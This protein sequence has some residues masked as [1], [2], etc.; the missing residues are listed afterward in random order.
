MNYEKL[1]ES[2]LTKGL[3]KKQMPNLRT[4]EK[5]ILRARKD[6]K[7]A[8]ATLT[9]DEGIAYAVA[10]LAMLRAGRAV[11]LL[12]GFR[13]AD[14][15]Q[16][17]TVV[18]FIS[19]L[20]GKEFSTIVAHFDNMRRKRNIFTYDISIAISKREAENALATAVEFVGLLEQFIKKNNP[21]MKF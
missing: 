16:H 10:Y 17:K 9:I 13:P 6:I 7:T 2:Y 5:L 19:S 12:K 4:V 14:G 3:L 21:Q 20:L 8:R 15:F 11:M 1:I 18:E